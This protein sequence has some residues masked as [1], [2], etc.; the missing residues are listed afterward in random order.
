MVRPKS[1]NK[2]QALVDAAIRLFLEQ[3][4]RRTRI[5]DIAAA[6][7]VAVGTFYTYFDDKSAIIRRLAHAFA[8]Q[9]HAFA[10]KILTS[11]AQPFTKLR[12]YVLGFYDLWQPFGKNTRGAMELAD[13]IIAHAPET[14]DIARNEF[15]GTIQTILEEAQLA[16]YDIKQ[17]AA[18]ARLLV[19][20]TTAFFPLAG[21]PTTRPLNAALGREDL[22]ELLHWIAERYRR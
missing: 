14:L 8:E 1:D 4:I 3:G 13:A 16:G 10:R 9:H 11:R 21:T 12:N 20:S 15:L 22:A 7:S 19:V 2:D 17:P 6:A 18:E 5:Q